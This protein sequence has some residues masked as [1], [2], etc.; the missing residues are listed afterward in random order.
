MSLKE[1]IESNPFVYLIGV[2]IGTATV[3]T[4]VVGYFYTQ[5]KNGAINKLESRLI[6]IDRRIVGNE[7]LDVRTF[8]IPKDQ[9]SKVPTSSRFIPED[10]FYAS[11]D[12]PGWQYS[13]VTEA[14]LVKLTIGQTIPTEFS[15]AYSI[16][17]VVHTWQGGPALPVEGNL[18]IKSV[19][20]IIAV[21]RTS[22]DKL[23]EIVKGFS[24]AIS[25]PGIS[26]VQDQSAQ[27]YGEALERMYRGDIIGFVYASQLVSILSLAQIDSKT[28]GELRAVQSVGN[29][30]YSRFRLTLKDVIVDH[31]PYAQYY[32]HIEVILISTTKDLYMIKTLLPSS[33]PAPRGEI[34]KGI[35]EWFGEL[36]IP[37]G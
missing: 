24:E 20:P 35:N 27:K 16:A 6:S 8:I 9:E 33:E 11:Q 21:Q 26:P 5:S 2:I 32:I 23:S 31:A 36:A 22:L 19:V 13:K 7:F 15:Q 30:L 4:G 14:D 28:S 25:A 18:A 34:Y 29:I 17:P 1:Q 37:V 3:V 12:L 10:G